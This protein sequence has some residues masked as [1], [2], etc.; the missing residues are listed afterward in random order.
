MG[1]GV[2][3]TGL[4]FVALAVALTLELR[5]TMIEDATHKHRSIHTLAG[6]TAIFVRCGLARSGRQGGAAVGTELFVVTALATAVYLYGFRQAFKLESRPSKHRLAAGTALYVAEMVG[7][8]VPRLRLRVRALRRGCRDDAQR[9]VHH[10]RS[11]AVGRRCT[12]R[13]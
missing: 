10:P 13:S 9:R 11:L 5:A 4:V 3:L 7:A 8:L 12:A 1:G 2:A 6:L